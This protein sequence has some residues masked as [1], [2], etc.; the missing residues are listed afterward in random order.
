MPDQNELSGKSRAIL[1]NTEFVDPRQEY[2]EQQERKRLAFEADQEKKRQDFEAKLETQKAKRDWMMLIITFAAVAAAYWTGWEARQA[3]LDGAEIGR[4]SLEKQQASVD[5]QIDATHQ[6]HRPYIVTH[7]AILPGVGERLG[8]G[9]F[10]SGDLLPGKSRDTFQIIL[11]NPGQTP[12]LDVHFYG[13]VLGSEQYH[14]FTSD[15]HK[16]LTMAVESQSFSQRAVYSNAP[17]TQSFGLPRFEGPYY[18][19]GYILYHDL[20]S[21]S[22]RTEFCYHVYVANWHV[23]T[24]DEL[25]QSRPC[26]NFS[27]QV[28]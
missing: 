26:P 18:V 20:F 10:F 5:A 7:T 25:P 1:Q 14:P 27:P 28:S 19:I 17:A 13:A 2:A 9:V 22:H 12:A 4:K 16:L 15:P 24:K 8:K 23:L 6:E 21:L 3:R 11:E